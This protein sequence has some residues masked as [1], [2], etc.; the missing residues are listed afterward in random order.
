MI[1]YILSVLIFTLSTFLIPKMIISQNVAFEKHFIDTDFKGIHVIKV[2]DIDYDGDYDVVG[3]SEHTPT[4]TSVGIA[5]WRNDGGDPVQWTKFVVDNT[6]L[7]VM[8][9]D[10]DTINDDESYDIVASSWENGTICWWESSGDPTQEWTKHTIVSGW[11]NAHASAC[12]DLD[13]DGKVDVV[14]T[15]VANNKVSVFYNSDL[16]R[17]SHCSSC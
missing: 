11:T 7:H 17:S 5:W 12:S 15:S 9:I 14:G 13:K 10:V 16:S 8:S 1:K 6:F 3:G 2:I 4:S